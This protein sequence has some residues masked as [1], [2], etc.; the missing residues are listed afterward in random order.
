MT[1]QEKA[2]QENRFRQLA[3]LDGR[4]ARLER[5]YIA[6]L[7]SSAYACEQTRAMKLAELN[8]EAN[9]IARER[10]FFDND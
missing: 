2:N 10:R 1:R 5:Q 7:R 9:D 6:A 4:E 8:R 3:I